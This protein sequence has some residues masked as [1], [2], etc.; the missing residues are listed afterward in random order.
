M[1]YTIKK[2][3]I[4]ISTFNKKSNQEAKKYFNNY[5]TKNYNLFLGC[6]LNLY[7]DKKLLSNAILAKKLYQAKYL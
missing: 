3:N 5:I 1:N 2:D 4:I 6:E 7:N